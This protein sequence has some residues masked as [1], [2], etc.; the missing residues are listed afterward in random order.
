MKKPL[1]LKSEREILINAIKDLVNVKHRISDLAEAKND[2]SNLYGSKFLDIEMEIGVLCSSL[3]EM[4]GYT[5]YSDI[6]EGLEVNP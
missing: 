6:C 5:V 1:S 2:V 4:V 3:G